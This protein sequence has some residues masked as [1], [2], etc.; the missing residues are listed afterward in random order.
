MTATLENHK[1]KTSKGRKLVYW[2]STALVA[3]ALTGIGCANLVRNPKIVE[4]LMRLGYPAYVAAILGIWQL[5]GSATII[6][7]GLPRLKE[8]AYAGMFFTLSGAALSHAVVG[9]SLAHILVPL[10]LL[11]AVMI[12]CALQPARVTRERRAANTQRESAW[13]LIGDDTGVPV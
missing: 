9:D 7:P 10:A 12:S 3:S 13:G 8:W 6:L 11:V 4:G 1:A 2:A 5:L